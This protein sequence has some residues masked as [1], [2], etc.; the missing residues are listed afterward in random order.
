MATLHIKDAIMFTQAQTTLLRA[1][2]T[3]RFKRRLADFGRSMDQQLLHLEQ[4]HAPRPGLR[5][6]IKSLDRLWGWKLKARQG[7]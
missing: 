2:I 7:R 3:E 1:R 4:R 6:F 5:R